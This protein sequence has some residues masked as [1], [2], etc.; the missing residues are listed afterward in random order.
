MDDVQQPSESLHQRTVQGIHQVLEHALSHLQGL[1]KALVQ[2]A[3]QVIQPRV[4]QRVQVATE[5]RLRAE[6]EY[7]QDLLATILNQ[8]QKPKKRPARKRGAKRVAP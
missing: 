6:L 3:V 1:E 7:L 5:S 8:P 4:T 2:R